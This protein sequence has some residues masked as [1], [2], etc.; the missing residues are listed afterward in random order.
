MTDPGERP[1]LP[2]WVFVGMVLAVFGAIVIGADLLGEPRATVLAQLRP[3]LWW[4]S[5]V[6]LAGILLL[7][8]G[9]RR[10]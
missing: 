8:F 1:P 2:I 9:R 7:V 5:I 6:L 4:G 3:G 10:A